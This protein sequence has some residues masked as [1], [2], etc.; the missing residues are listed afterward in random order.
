MKR[1]LVLAAC[2]GAATASLAAE[3][4]VLRPKSII[5]QEWTYSILVGN[6]PVSDL[7]SGERVT[8]EV[9]PQTRSLVVHCP[10][11]AG[12]YAESRIDYDFKTSTRAFFV[13]HTTSDCVKIEALDARGAGPFMRQTVERA[14]RAVDYDKGSVVAAPAAPA[15]IE[16]S[17]RG[18]VAAAT[19]AWADAF[20][21]RDLA[22]I[23]ALY[24]G[25]AVLTDA[26]EPR[27]RVGPAAITDYYKSA[28]QRPTQRVALGEQ[29][30]RV[31]GDT[32]IDSGTCTYFEMRDGK[33]TTTPCRYSVTYRSRG[34]RWLIVD[35]QSSLLAR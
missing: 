22:R 26:S 21:S 13:L 19:A 29:T 12:G 9:A 31:F 7:R 10:K 18:Q 6:E 33:A 15:S 34:G 4:T 11:F 20:N 23:A 8:F 14:N 2:A 5:A 28:A 3:V 32:A 27:P 35:H 1:W 17:A 24:D 30:I 25:D 16:A